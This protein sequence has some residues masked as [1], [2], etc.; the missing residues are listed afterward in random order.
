[1]LG[2]LESQVLDVVWRMKSATVREVKE[3]L[4][5]RRH[6][7]YTTVMT[8][9][10]RLHEKGFLVRTKRGK[11]YVYAPRVSRQEVGKSVMKKWLRN[12]LRA[13]GEPTMSCLV[14]AIREVDSRRLDE[15]ARLIEEERR[16]QQEG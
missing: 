4:R 13:F 12:M 2:E 6:I 15:L 8:T 1:M 5:H 9:M 11:G 7:A 16:R 10:D 14:E 3:H